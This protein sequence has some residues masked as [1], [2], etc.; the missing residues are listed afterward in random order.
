[1]RPLNLHGVVPCPLFSRVFYSSRERRNIYLFSL[2]HAL[3]TEESKRDYGKGSSAI[4][5]WPQTTHILHIVPL[6]NISIVFLA[7]EFKFTYMSLPMDQKSFSTSTPS[8]YVCVKITGELC[9]AHWEDK[10]GAGIEIQQP[11]WSIRTNTPLGGWRFPRL[12]STST[13]WS[14]VLSN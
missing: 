1:M 11:H 5:Q 9:G 13:Y 2:F 12:P 14:P 3:Q 4:P 10:Y 8:E 6:S 7:C